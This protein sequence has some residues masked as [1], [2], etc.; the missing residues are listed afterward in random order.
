MTAR[1]RS[2]LARA[3]LLS[4]STFVYSNQHY[5]H[6]KMV[7]PTVL[8]A[9]RRYV[10][11]LE[12]SIIE[13]DGR[14]PGAWEVGNG[15]YGGRADTIHKNLSFRRGRSMSSWLHLSLCLNGRTCEDRFKTPRCH[16]AG[17]DIPLQA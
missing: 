14:C 1:P 17:L 8:W 7:A 2:R 16:D 4:P 13:G 5:K 11:P 12:E 10:H 6:N 9:Q 3:L 15:A